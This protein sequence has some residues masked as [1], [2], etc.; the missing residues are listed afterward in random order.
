MATVRQRE[1]RRRLAIWRAL[2]SILLLAAGLFLWYWTSGISY[3]TLPRLGVSAGAMGLSVSAVASDDGVHFR[4]WQDFG[5][6]PEFR[7]RDLN[8]PGYH[9]GL[10]LN[11]LGVIV[12]AQPY[13][14]NG[15]DYIVPPNAA[16]ALPYWLL[17]ATASYGILRWT[18]LLH[19]LAPYCRFAIPA[20]AVMAIVGLVFLVLNVIPGPNPAAGSVSE[21][22]VSSVQRVDEWLRKFFDPASFGDIEQHYGFPFTF[23]EVGYMNGER[24]ELYYGAEME[25]L[26]HRLGENLCVALAAMVIAGMIVQC[27][28]RWRARP[29]G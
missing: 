13:T 8:Q 5:S 27:L 19:L 18:G 10:V 23:Y 21:S 4:L 22:G 16:I 2:G 7:W 26:Q 29:A 14:Y 28:S 24:V 6:R 9:H 11:L 15:G 12:A 1:G 20:L 17:I 25:Y 3:R